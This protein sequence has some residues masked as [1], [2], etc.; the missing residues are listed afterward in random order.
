LADGPQQ[1]PI[2]VPL[3]PGAYSGVLTLAA[4]GA[5]RLWRRVRR[6]GGGGQRRA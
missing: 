2:L 3:P 4:L 5:A 1:E 6:G